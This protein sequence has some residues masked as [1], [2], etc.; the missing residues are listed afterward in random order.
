MGCIFYFCTQAEHTMFDNHYEAW[1]ASRNAGITKYI[2]DSFFPGKTL[3][4]VGA[5]YGHNGQMFHKKGCI[6][7]CS[8]AR[9]EHIVSGKL[10]HPHLD[11]CI[12]DCE[13]DVLPP[14]NILLHWGVLYHLQNIDDHFIKVANSCDYL[15]LETEVC[16]SSD[17][18]VLQTEEVGFDQAYSG[19]GSRP[20]PC[21]VESLLKK[22]GFA[23]K[24]ILDPI[25]NASFHKYDWNIEN[26]GDWKHG[27]RRFWIAW[28]QDV[29]CP[30]KEI[31]RNI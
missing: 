19:I 3:L 27:L 16:D 18:M 1:R 14:C 21:Y 28:K 29:E 10:L 15:F 17:S 26:K 23:Y 20:S 31:Y 22:H 9:S 7:T 24:L 8:D 4:E 11:F 2:D 12:L 30:I 6:V 13:K 25:L 5:G